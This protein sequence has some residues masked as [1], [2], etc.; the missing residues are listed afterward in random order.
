[1]RAKSC[2][3][4]KFFLHF[5]I[6][7]GGLNLVPVTGG[8]LKLRVAGILGSISRQLHGLLKFWRVSPWPLPP[9]SHSLARFS[10]RTASSALKAAQSAA[11][12]EAEARQSGTEARHPPLW[13]S[14]SPLSAT[15]K[16]Q[17][18]EPRRV[19]YGQREYTVVNN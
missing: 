7:R 15:Q 17:K 4:L 6:F 5:S 1:M 10:W 12:A 2:H 11:A 13:A 18:W 8:L 16:P 9:W 3:C 19:G 14:P